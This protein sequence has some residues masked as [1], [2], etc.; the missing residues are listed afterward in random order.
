MCNPYQV[1][2]QTFCHAMLITRCKY[3][4]R[5]HRPRGPNW[6]ASHSLIRAEC[7]HNEEDLNKYMYWM[8]K[9]MGDLCK[10]WWTRP[11]A[12]TKTKTKNSWC[13]K[14]AHLQQFV[15]RIWCSWFDRIRVKWWPHFN[16]N[17]SRAIIWIR[18]KQKTDEAVDLFALLT[19]HGYLSACESLYLRMPE[20]D[21]WHVWEQ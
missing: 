17:L 15:M 10:Y 7:I 6:T 20:L 12:A 5:Q 8:R 9:W 21:A 4:T 13:G 19:Q 14:F 3:T 18:I 16:F 11:T 2:C 1:H